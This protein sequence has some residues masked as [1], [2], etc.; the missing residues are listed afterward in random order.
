MGIVEVVV[1]ARA[2]ELDPVLYGGEVV[3]LVG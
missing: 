3:A 1:E 2:K